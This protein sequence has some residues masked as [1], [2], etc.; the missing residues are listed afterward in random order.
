MT[1]SKVKVWKMS[2]EEKV[3]ETEEKEEPIE[4]ETHEEEESEEPIEE[5]VAEKKPW[6]KFW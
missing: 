6:W 5:R 4:E 2:V 3:E 1:L